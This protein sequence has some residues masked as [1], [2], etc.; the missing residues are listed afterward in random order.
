[1]YKKGDKLE[2]GNYRGITLLNTAYKVFANILYSRL[3][4]YAEENIGEYQCGFRNDR[5]TT[6]QLFAI[7]QILEK[8]R[9]FS[10][11]THHLFVDFKAAYDSVSRTM[12]WGIMEEFGFPKKLISLTRLTLSEV[13]SK[14]RVR[15]K[16]SFAF[17]TDDGLRQGD[18][19]ATLLFNIV[20]EKAIRNTCVDKDGNIFTKSCQLL[21]YADDVD[22]IGRNAEHVKQTF[23]SLTNAASSVGLRVNV[24][25]TKYMMVPKQ[26]NFP[27]HV[28]IQNN[29]F[30]VVDNFKYLGSQINS[31]ND[32]GE[33]V[34]ARIASGNRCYYGLRKFFQSKT[35]NRELK[36]KVYKQLVR[37]IVMYGS[38]T[39]CMTQKH[40]SY[41]RGF[42]KKI[43]RCIYGAIYENSRWR[44][45]FD[46]E[47][48]R[49]F[50]GPDIVR[51]IK[52]GR[53]RWLGHVSRMGNHRTPKR[54]FESKPSGT[55]RAGRPKLR[56]YDAITRDLNA[57]QVRDWRS[58]AG[59][60]IDWRRLLQEALTDKLL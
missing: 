42:E 17:G 31:N 20:L 25:K 22:I 39:W 43:L 24:N 12:L 29:R 34:M 4:P 51:C 26:D 44:R 50:G 8:C 37:P 10:V 5:S 60:R 18:P 41:L 36:C 21:A 59:N 38:E 56:W 27:D 9:E 15:G 6:D 16:V 1:M 57:L 3:L 55:R 58:M 52:V 23:I 45:R 54:L 2:C 40:E 53:L 11:I 7:R 14:V 19:L 48:K 49:L 32:I 33:E 47:L 13:I 30:N 46:F 28:T 35:L